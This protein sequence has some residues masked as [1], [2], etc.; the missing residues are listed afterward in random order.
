MK[1]TTFIIDDE[2]HAIATLESYALKSD[3]LDVVGTATDPVSALPALTGKN[4]PDLLF[5]DIDMP[6]ISGL[7]LARLISPETSIIFVTAF[8]EFGVEAFELSAADYLLKPISYARFYNAVQKVKGEHL[9][10]V[11]EQGFFFVKGDVKEKFIKIATSKII[12][13]AAA[14]NYVEVV[15]TDETVMTYLTLTELL[16]KLPDADFCQIHRSFVINRNYLKAIEKT[17]VKM[18][19]AKLIPI[20]PSYQKQFLAWLD[21]NFI[22]SKRLS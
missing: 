8:R 17:D 4:P 11:K 12:Y 3:A 20:G 9:G 13:I 2:A 21:P 22:V 15:M 7:E 14:M 5:L 19:N 18:D 1:L 10:N 16:D 6:G